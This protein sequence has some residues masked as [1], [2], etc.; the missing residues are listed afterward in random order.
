MATV[1]PGVG[2][3]PAQSAET[4]RLGAVV[5]AYGDPNGA[6]AVTRSLVGTMPAQDIMVVQNPSGPSDPP[7]PPPAPGV[8]VMRMPSNGGYATAMNAGVRALMSHPYTH[9]LLLTQDAGL[10]DGTVSTLIGHLGSGRIGVIAPTLASRESGQPW[11]YGGSTDRR[12]QVSHRPT[13][14]GSGPLVEADWVDGACIVVARQLLEDVGLFDGRFFLYFEEADLCL[15]ARRA[16]WPVLVALDARAY[17]APGASRR[18]GAYEFL[19]T[20]NGI[21]YARRLGGWRAVLTALNANRDKLGA[22]ASQGL[23]RGAPLRTEHGRARTY[24]IV[25]GALAFFLRRWG[26]PPAWLPGLGD[27]KFTKPPAGSDRNAA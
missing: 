9:F 22:L 19:M 13:P 23:R 25:L 14:R 27:I 26:P 4:T 20:R 15:R 7:L 3:S 2:P 17:Q 1:E 18:Q 12:G 21:E 10:E 16:G 6:A 24:G 11:S 5:L 8:R